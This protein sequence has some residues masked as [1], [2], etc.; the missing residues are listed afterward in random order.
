MARGPHVMSEFTPPSPIR[1]AN[2]RLGDTPAPKRGRDP[3]VARVGA[4][5]I[6]GLLGIPI[7][8]AINHDGGGSVEAQPTG[9]AA[10]LL[11]TGNGAGSIALVD[12]TASSAAA[13]ALPATGQS[14]AIALVDPATTAGA[15]AAQQATTPTTVTSAST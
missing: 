10:A 6:V 15:V 1:R 5:V 13:P 12:P 2:V 11:S 7:V 14:G 3:F 4:L 8:A 9:G